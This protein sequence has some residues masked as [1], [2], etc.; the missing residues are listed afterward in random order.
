MSVPV[1]VPFSRRNSYVGRSFSD[2]D[3]MFNNLFQNAM[4]NLASPAGGFGDLSVRLDVAETETAYALTAELPGI[5]EKEIELTVND[6]VLTLK[7][8]RRSD[9]EEEG[10]T[11]HRVERTYGRFSRVLQLPADADENA[12]TAFMRNGVLHIDIGKTK[13][14]AKISKRID[15][16]RD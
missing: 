3:R 5:D 12:V 10:K 14:A 6:G 2:F 16:K 15:I 7:G 13:E 9:K 1:L 11:W 8:E 4:S